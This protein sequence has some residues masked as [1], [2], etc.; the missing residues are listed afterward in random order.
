[1]S[2]SCQQPDITVL[3]P[4]YN[5]EPFITEAVMSIL[6]QSYTNFVL[7]IIDDGSTDRTGEILEDLASRDS[8]IALY[9]RENR[10]LIATL[11]EGLSL[12]RTELVARMDADD[13]ALPDRLVMQKDFMDAHPEVAV[14]GTCCIFHESNEVWRYPFDTPMDIL[15]LFNASLIHPSV[16]FRRSIIR[17]VGGYHTDMVAAEDYELWVRLLSQGVQLVNLATP[18]LRYRQH[19]HMPRLSYRFTAEQSTRKIWRQQLSRLGIDATER[20]LDV[21]A[22]CA[23]PCRETRAGLRRVSQWLRRICD[24]NKLTKIY[25]QEKL[26]ARCRAMQNAFPPPL[27]WAREPRAWFARQCRHLIFA[28]CRTLGPVGEKVLWAMKKHVLAQRHR[29]KQHI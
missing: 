8:R 22:F 11:N 1:M 14:C 29:D 12:C 15:F 27:D 16:M 21:H 7:L 5:A 24:A 26:E 17:D 3:L 25:D 18:L 23:S 2:S 4:A 13:I 28:V 19:P 20:E 6:Q 9:R 10:G